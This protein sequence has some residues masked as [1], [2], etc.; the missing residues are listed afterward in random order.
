MKR[1]LTVA[2]SDS[3]GGAG[4]QADLK[5]IT[6]LGAFGMSAIT[7]LTAQNTQRVQSIHD[8]P[9]EFVREQIETVIS[10]LGVDSVKTGM[11]SN[12]ALV[13]VVADT[14]SERGVEKLVVDPVMVAKSGDRLLSDD[15]VATVIKR[16]IPLALVVTPN[17]TEAAILAD[18]SIDSDADLR[19]AARTIH[20]MGA[21]CVLIKGGHREG[22]AED[23][24]FDGDRFSTFQTDRIRSPHTHGTG[25]VYSAAIATFLAMGLEVEAAVEKAKA[26]VQEAIE[27]PL[28]LGKGHGPTNVYAPFVRELGR[29]QV[30]EQ[31]KSALYRLQEARVGH[32]IP[33]VQSNLGY[34]LPYARGRQDVA[35]F[36]GRLVRLRDSVASL[37]GPVFGA[38]QHISSI[39]LTVMHHHPDVRS[40]MNLR[41]SESRLAHCETLKWHVASFDRRDEPKDKK[42]REGS[43]LEWGTDLVLSRE[44]SVPDV[45]FDRGEVGK[46]PMIRIL[47]RNPQEIVDKVVQLKET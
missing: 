33:E 5:T 4:I 15:A 7:A 3:G 42:D 47:G 36:P 28:P 24:F 14:L 32:L 31:L 8:V 35:A 13:E 21:T 9:P 39:I 2:G 29:Y 6:L 16:L 43:S 41:F 44:S 11:L 38:S 17:L 34:A 26:F 30:L 27:C 18:T 25:C 40:A 22:P 20:G 1:V 23:L 12:P 10:D 46:E 45:I 19:Q 37:T